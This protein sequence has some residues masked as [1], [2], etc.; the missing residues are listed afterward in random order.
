MIKPG[1]KIF[2]VD[3]ADNV[4]VELQVGNLGKH[5]FQ[6][7][8]LLGNLQFNFLEASSK[9]DAQLLRSAEYNPNL[10]IVKGM[11]LKTQFDFEKPKDFV[12]FSR[13]ESAKKF[14]ILRLNEFLFE[15]CKE[16]DKV[17]KRHLELLKTIEEFELKIDQINNL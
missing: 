7:N 1:K 17:V 5:N 10:Y 8:L 9:L 15:N 11:C 16:H 13:K 2:V 3:L 14:L 6:S 12:L 4:I